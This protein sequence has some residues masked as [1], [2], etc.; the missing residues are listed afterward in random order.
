M[1]AISLFSGAGGD[2]CG[3]HGAGIDVVA[4]SEFDKNAVATHL[5]NFPRC[6]WI[7]HKD[8]GDITKVPD[9]VFEKYKN[10]IDI[11]FAGFPCQSFSH[12]GK[13]KATEDPRGQLFLEFARVSRLI[14]PKYIIGENVVGLLRRRTK[15]G[16]LVFDLIKKTFE[17]MGY[18]I[19][20]KVLDSSD[21]ETPQ[22]RK[23]L[24]FVGV[25]DTTQRTFEFP[26][27]TDHKYLGSILEPTLHNTLKVDKLPK[28]TTPAFDDLDE[29][30]FSNMT[31]EEKKY[32]PFLKVN[33][34]RNTISFAKR[35]SPIHIEICDKDS[36]AKTI[37]CAYSFQPR[38]VVALKTKQNN[39]YIRTFTTTELALIQGFPVNYHFVGNK[40]SIIKQIGNA[41]PPNVVKAIAKSIIH[42]HETTVSR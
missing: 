29:E 33:S 32:H 4:F 23:R 31:D 35:D 11:V 36:F 34:D 5:H 18:K 6:S 10:E 37:I 41:V 1:K 27:E 20:H 22:K 12:A 26:S 8:N 14:C 13:K 39:S 42:H 21:F 7:N 40:N 30:D 24:F 15:D 25:K 17:D 3:L 9:E 28:N 19:H 38:L 2:T 16:K